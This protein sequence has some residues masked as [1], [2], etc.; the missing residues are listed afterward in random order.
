MKLGIVRQAFCACA[1][2]F[3]T[4]VMAQGGMIAPGAITA[5]EIWESHTGILVRHAEMRDPDSCGRSDWY[6]LPKTHP[7]FKEAYAL[8]ISAQS[9]GKQ[10]QLWLYK[11]HEGL[12]KIAHLATN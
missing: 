5:L 2:L 11:C 8:L 3:S 9:S 4:S 7:M 1:L 12:P 10:V 6:I